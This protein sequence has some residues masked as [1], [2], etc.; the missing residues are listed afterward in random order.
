MM[1][2]CYFCYQKCPECANINSPLQIDSKDR[3]CPQTW[4]KQKGQVNHILILLFSSLKKLWHKLLKWFAWSHTHKLRKSCVWSRAAGR[5]PPEPQFSASPTVHS[6]FSERCHVITYYSKLLTS[7]NSSF[8]YKRRSGHWQKVVIA[9]GSK[10]YNW[11][12]RALCYT[13][14]L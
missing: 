8:S 12:C 1:E 10:D 5:K 6:S 4:Y 7:L 14:C 11:P 9:L 2:I 13:F 3:L